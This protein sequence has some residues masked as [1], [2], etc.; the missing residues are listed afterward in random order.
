MN[1]TMH[2]FLFISQLFEA[3][4]YRFIQNLVTTAGWERPG[5]KN[6]PKTGSENSATIK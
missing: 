4:V 3:T 1:E 6:P 2:F 5:T